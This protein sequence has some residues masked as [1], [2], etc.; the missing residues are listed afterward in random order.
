M[1]VNT[2]LASMMPSY[3]VRF[4]VCSTVTGLLNSS[5]YLG[6]ALSSYGNGAIVEHFGW[7]SILYCWCIAAAI[8]IVTLLLS[9]RKWKHF[10]TL[11]PANQL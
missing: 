11:T 5:A 7:N 2:L 6:S 4:G 9:A 10:R 3:Y 1:G 8:G